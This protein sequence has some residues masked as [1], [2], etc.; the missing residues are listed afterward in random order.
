MSI[1]AFF[2]IIAALSYALGYVMIER[3][4]ETLSPSTYMFY[5]LVASIVVLAVIHFT[6]LDT[7]NLDFKSITTTN[8]LLIFGASTVISIGFL[9]TIFATKHISSS[10]AAIGEISYVLFVPV[11]A[12]L[13]FGIK[14]FN[15]SMVLGGL[16]IF[17][18]CVILISGQA[19][20]S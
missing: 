3:V 17:T 2:P 20:A 19:K 6:K 15:M 4:V 8:H 7:I 14:N 10:Y 12:Y 18:G 13:I 5:G 1:Y 11:F 16:L 9:A